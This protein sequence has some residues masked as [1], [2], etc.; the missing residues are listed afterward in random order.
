LPAKIYLAYSKS[1]GFA[2]DNSTNMKLPYSPY[3]YKD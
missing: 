1:V 2:A 3:R